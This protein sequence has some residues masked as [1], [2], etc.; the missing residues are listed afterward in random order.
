MTTQKIYIASDHG[1]T[2]GAN[3]KKQLVE[4]L[5]AQG[6][7]V[8]DL[9]PH[10]TQSVDYP[11]Y[12]HKVAEAMR[13]SPTARGVLICGSGTGMDMAANKHDHIRAAVIHA[14]ENATEL[15]TLARTHNNANV[16]CFGARFVTPETAKACVDTFMTTERELGRHERRADKITPPPT[17]RRVEA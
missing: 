12:A 14:N 13:K 3:L 10:D 9:G 7:D 1:G 4:H 16:L 2:E 17:S 11:D 5:Q 15:T 8:E 6:H